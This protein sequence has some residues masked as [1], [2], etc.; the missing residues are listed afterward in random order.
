MPTFADVERPPEFC[1]LV[2]VV[3]DEE[4]PPEDPEDDP[5][6]VGWLV[7]VPVAVASPETAVTS[8][9]VVAVT[10]LAAPAVD[11]PKSTGLEDFL[12]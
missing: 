4:D 10:G 1:W 11:V 12:S 5:V 3:E 9:A 7:T 8:A 2:V 6:A